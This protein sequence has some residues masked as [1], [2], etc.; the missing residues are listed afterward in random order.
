MTDI[1]YIKLWYNPTVLRQCS[2]GAPTPS[3]TPTA[4]AQRILCIVRYFEHAALA[5]EVQPNVCTHLALALQVQPLALHSHSKCGEKP[6][7]SMQVFAL[8][9]VWDQVAK[10]V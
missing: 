9:V 5:L 10:R 6:A 4:R 3:D 1:P 2:D 7:L 8:N